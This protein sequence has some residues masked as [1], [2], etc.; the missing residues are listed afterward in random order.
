MQNNTTN[1]NKC[2]R[3]KFNQSLVSHSKD[4]VRSRINSSINKTKRMEPGEKYEYS[5]LFDDIQLK[6]KKTISKKLC[7]HGS[8]SDTQKILKARK[9]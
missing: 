7:V 1:L 2:Y 6:H 5:H 8:R 9:L 3:E 4:K